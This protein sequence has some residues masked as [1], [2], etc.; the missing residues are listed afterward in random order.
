[1]PTIHQAPSLS[2]INTK[3]LIPFKSCL[4]ILLN[5]ASKDGNQLNQAYFPEP[6]KMTSACQAKF[7]ELSIANATGSHWGTILF[8]RGP[9]CE[10]VEP[11]FIDSVCG[12][13]CNMTLL[14]K[15]YSDR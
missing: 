5:S 14:P 1:M 13:G 2:P 4:P 8:E 11:T 3:G 9:L 6:V 10:I 12:G 15:L 7:G